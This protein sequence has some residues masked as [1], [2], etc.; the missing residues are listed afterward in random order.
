MD[1]NFRYKC[2]GM[3]SIG[4]N[5]LSIT[6]TPNKDDQLTS[7]DVAKPFVIVLDAVTARQFTVG[8]EYRIDF[9]PV[10]TILVPPTP[11]VPDETVS[12]IL[13]T[14]T[15]TDADQLGGAV[16]WT[17]PLDVTGITH[18]VIYTS[19]DGSSRSVK[20]GEVAVGT[21]N[22]V[23]PENTALG[24]ATHIAVYAKNAVGEAIVGTY[25]AITDVTA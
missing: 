13:F 25:K 1:L 2:T 12:A 17:S 14:D 10:E 8:K 23:I 19:T 6:L 20:L 9:I 5:L 18:Y 15:D 4:A 11:T 3:S 24:G 7:S 21:N 22:F 16:S